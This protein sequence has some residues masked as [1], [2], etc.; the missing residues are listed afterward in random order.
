MLIK[1]TLVI[2]VNFFITYI[3]DHGSIKLDKNIKIKI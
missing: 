2:E 1:L 3:F